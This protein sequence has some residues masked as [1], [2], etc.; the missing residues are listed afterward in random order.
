M[1]TVISTWALIL[2]GGAVAEAQSTSA[3][4]T[5]RRPRID[6]QREPRDDR[7]L[8]RVDARMD[9]RTQDSCA[10]ELRQYA[11]KVDELEERLHKQHISW[12]RGHDGERENFI[13]QHE[14]LHERLDR[15]RK[16][17]RSAN[18]PPRCRPG[19]GD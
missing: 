18:P 3:E 4:H 15:A 12:H 9:S 16:Q 17:W 8:G 10:L 11:R 19:R 7:S 13:R 1:A 14:A 2:A 6:S 5:E